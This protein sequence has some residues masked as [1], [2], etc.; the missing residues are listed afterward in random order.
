MGVK[1]KG[2]T[3]REMADSASNS[4][5]VARSRAWVV[6]RVR[7]AV[8][9]SNFFLK[10]ARAV[11]A[12]CAAQACGLRECVGNLA[13]PPGAVQANV[14][15]MRATNRTLSARARFRRAVLY[16]VALLIFFA[17]LTQWHGLHQADGAGA[18]EFAPR[19]QPPATA[20]P[21]APRAPANDVIDQPIGGAAR[22]D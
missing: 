21:A 6:R 22:Q 14:P 15:S 9:D 11:T 2:Q 7:R 18:M 12:V 8:H 20:A 13:F 10:R 19:R 4:L 16:A 5:G 3:G 17:T 1:C